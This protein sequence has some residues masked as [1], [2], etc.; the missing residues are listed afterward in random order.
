MKIIFYP[1][2]LI[3]SNIAFLFRYAK[4]SSL[5]YKPISIQS[6]YKRI[7]RSQILINKIIYTNENKALKNYQPINDLLTEEYIRKNT[8]NS[9][10]ARNWIVKENKKTLFKVR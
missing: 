8:I 5:D 7:I 4:I 9:S 1:E 3:E 6:C 10:I 2:R